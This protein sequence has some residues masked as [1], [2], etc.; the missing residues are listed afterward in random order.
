VVDSDGDAGGVEL[1]LLATRAPLKLSMGPIGSGEDVRVAVGVGVAAAKEP[2]KLLD[3]LL[4]V[5]I[6]A[7]SATLLCG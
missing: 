6:L 2:E 1:S 4:L 3:V 5:N 7:A